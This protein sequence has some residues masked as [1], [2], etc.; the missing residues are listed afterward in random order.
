MALHCDRDARVTAPSNKH[1]D[2]DQTQGLEQ[3]GAIL[4]TPSCLVFPN[5][6]IFR[7]QFSGFFPNKEMQKSGLIATFYIRNTFAPPTPHYA[8]Q[9][10]PHSTKPS[11]FANHKPLAQ[12][13]NLYTPHHA[14]PHST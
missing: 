5:P 4:L 11:A 7:I 9:T 12:S 13:A 6:L 8:P 2:S 3:E 10:P 14:P 1:S